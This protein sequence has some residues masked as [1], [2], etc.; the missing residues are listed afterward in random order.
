MKKSD[1]SGIE[2][3]C[4]N[5]AHW[6]DDGCALQSVDCI[7][8]LFNNKK[9][10]RF[11]AKDE[12]E[13]VSEIKQGGDVYKAKND[14]AFMTDEYLVKA[15]QSRQ[16]QNPMYPDVR[17]LTDESKKQLRKRKKVIS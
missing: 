1:M 15:Q 14:L 8:A 10:T 4:L 12:V 7:T 9:P 17:T 11:L 3:Y 16:R 6:K 5:C 2:K 13:P